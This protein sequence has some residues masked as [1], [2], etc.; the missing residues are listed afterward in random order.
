MENQHPYNWTHRTS[1]CIDHASWTN[2]RFG[3]IAL[4]SAHLEQI[5]IKEAYNGTGNRVQYFMFAIDNSAPNLEICS[6]DQNGEN[7]KLLLSSETFG[8]N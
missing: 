7:Q 5:H 8:D 2:W 3:W 6:S 4:S 1:S